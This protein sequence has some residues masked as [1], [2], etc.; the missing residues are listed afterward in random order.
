MINT[1]MSFGD[2]LDELRRRLIWAIAGLVVAT[3]LCFNVGDRI[4]EV[5]TTPYCVAMERLG[6]D[7]RMVQ[8]NPIESFMEYFKISLKFGLVLAAPWILYQLW[9][10]VAVGLYASE[11]RVVKYFAP[12]SIVLFIT[13]AAFMVFIV[14]A[15]VLQFLIGISTWFPLPS[16]QSFMY[17]L[18]GPREVAQ[19]TSQPSLPPLDVP[20]LSADPPS[21]AEGQIWFNAQ[22]QHLN[23]RHGNETYYFRMQRTSD[24]QFVQPFFSVSEYLGFVVNLALAFG[25]GF[26]IP[27]VVVF[28]I[29]VGIVKAADLSKARKYIILI[30]AVLA[31]VLTPTPDVGTMLLLMVPMILLFEVGLLFGRMVERRRTP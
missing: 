25:C 15:G 29:A 20:V 9:K 31:A 5:L 28:L 24:R 8:L 16:H 30:V 11:R 19:A 14:L 18:Y 12:S 17:K 7:P 2:H 1:R 4:I 22:S 23:L 3:V 27:I 6:F 26:Q 21:P 13:G 10:F